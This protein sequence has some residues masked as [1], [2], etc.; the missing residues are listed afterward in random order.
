VS[1]SRI[2]RPR[3]V[4]I[5][6]GSLSGVSATIP[7]LERIHRAGTPAVYGISQNGRRDTRKF[8]EDFSVKESLSVPIS[9]PSGPASSPSACALC[10]ASCISGIQVL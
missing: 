1:Q 9:A 3:A 8:N 2:K 6:Q 4:R 10:A 7:F 5:L